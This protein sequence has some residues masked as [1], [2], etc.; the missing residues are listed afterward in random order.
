MAS[1]IKVDTISEKTS[2]NGVTID[3]VNIKDGKVGGG[4]TITEAD[5]WRLTAN[6][7]NTNADITSNLE[8]IDTAPQGYLGTGMSESSGIFTFPSTG[9]WQV[10]VNAQIDASDNDNTLQVYTYGTTDNFSSEVILAKVRESNRG[11][12]AGGNASGSSQTLIDVT[13][14]SNIKVKFGT[15]SF[16]DDDSLIGSS[17]INETTFTFIRLGD[18]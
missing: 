16:G 9:I 2:A 17:T 18:T 5:Q 13:D 6:I 12:G 1:E 14:T 8:R 11:S 7:T 3:G 10:T 15:V 4:Y